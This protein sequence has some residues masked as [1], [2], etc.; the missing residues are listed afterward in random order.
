MKDEEKEKK[1]K[2]KDK[3]EKHKGA[4]EP[5]GDVRPKEKRK[6]EGEDAASSKRRKAST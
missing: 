2:K 3:K 1:E 4:H 6:S 5:S